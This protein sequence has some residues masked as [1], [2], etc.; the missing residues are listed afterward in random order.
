MEQEQRNGNAGTSSTLAAPGAPG[1]GWYQPPQGSC[2]KPKSQQHW[3]GLLKFL[4]TSGNVIDHNCACSHC[5]VV[6]PKSKD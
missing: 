3:T 2:R 1:T 6:M 4:L 5:P